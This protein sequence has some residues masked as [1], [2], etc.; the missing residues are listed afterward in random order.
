MQRCAPERFRWTTLLPA[1]SQSSPD[2]DQSLT[3][4][5]L[6][7]LALLSS[8]IQIPSA[9]RLACA[10]VPDLEAVGA[11]CGSAWAPV[12]G[13]SSHHL[14]FDP[15]AASSEP[16]QCSA[17]CGKQIFNLLACTVDE[18]QEQ[19]RPAEVTGPLEGDTALNPVQLALIG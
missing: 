17:Q 5:C 18:A 14:H 9:C 1:S 2:A 15:D 13:N 10:T 3:A 12:F 7:H 16:T 19:V 8:R 6:V 11:A 4:S